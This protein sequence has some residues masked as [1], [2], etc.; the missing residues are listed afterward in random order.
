LEQLALLG[1]SFL[2]TFLQSTR[3]WQ[4]LKRYVLAAVARSLRT[5]GHRVYG[6]ARS[7]AKANQLVRE[8]I[9]PVLG[10]AANPEGWAS[11]I[12]KIHVDV[13][14]DCS[15]VYQGAMDILK[16]CAKISETRIQKFGEGG[17]KAA[18]LGFVYLSGMWVQ[19]DSKEYGN[20]LL[21]VGANAPV[22]PAEIVAWR[23][24]IENEVLRQSKVLNG[25][26]LRAG[27][28]FGGAGSFIGQIWWS[29]IQQAI[30]NGD[31]TVELAA[32]PDSVLGLVHKDDVGQAFVKTVEKV[33]SEPPFLSSGL[34]S[35]ILM[36]NEVC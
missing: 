13:V 29:P 14:I 2:L 25:V 20:E 32:R 35:L 1:V 11:A 36:Q 31:K 27:L 30:A 19:G 22:K 23:V 5:Q 7:P 21:P 12:E 8:E 15:G 9:I 4:S 16:T 24:D 26:V 3:W 33:R 17:A 28:L 6:L 10:D 34:T 18:K